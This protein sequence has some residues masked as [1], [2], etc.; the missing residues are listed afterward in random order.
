MNFF[1]IF[2][3]IVTFF[4]LSSFAVDYVDESQ[5]RDSGAF[6]ETN[7]DSGQISVLTPFEFMRRID[8]EPTNS[9]LQYAAYGY[10]YKYSYSCGLKGM[11]PTLTCSWDWGWG[12][13]W[14]C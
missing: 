14:D 6:I 8:S 12:W 9:N 5:L 10:C 13:Y 7:L 11:P 1:I 2:L 4:N 3:C